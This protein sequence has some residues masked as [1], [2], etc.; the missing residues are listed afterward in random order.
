MHFLFLEILDQEI[1]R[2]LSELRCLLSK[3]THRT[4]IH[5]TIIGPRE[6]KPRP[7]KTIERFLDEKHALKIS[8]VGR[9][10]NHSDHVIYLAA[11]ISGLRTHK[12]WNKSDYPAFNPHITLYK[13]ND[14]AHADKVYHHLKDQG[15][16]LET[17]DYDIIPYCSGQPDLLST[18]KRS[19]WTQ[20]IPDN[21]QRILAE[22]KQHFAP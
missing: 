5:I 20:S 15:I 12:L 9:F 4:N 8:G 7:K 1:V 13:G 19:S 2:F 17:T 10:I 3:K 16:S 6:N 22:I 21:N 14:T 18:Q 11:E